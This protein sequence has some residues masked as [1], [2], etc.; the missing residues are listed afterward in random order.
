MSDTSVVDVALDAK[1]ADEALVRYIEKL[2]GKGRAPASCDDLASVLELVLDVESAVLR[3]EDRDVERKARIAELNTRIAQLEA[4]PFPK[5]A[6][7]HV[8]GKTYPEATLVTH[9][10]SLWISTSAVEATPGS[11][12]AAWKLIVKSGATR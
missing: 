3:M 12:G 6:G 7:V 10:G 8:D 2:K 5:W 1:A 9:R 4:R 11:P